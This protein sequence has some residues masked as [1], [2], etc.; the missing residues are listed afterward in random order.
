MTEQNPDDVV[1]NN[2]PDNEVNEQHSETPNEEQ[3]RIKITDIV[4]NLTE[5]NDC[6]KPM[7][8]KTLRYSHPSV[9]E[10]KPSNVID[11]PV[12]KYAPRAKTKINVEPLA[13]KQQEN[14]LV[15]PQQYQEK[16]QPISEAMLPQ[17][18][19][20]PQVP[21]PYDN[22]TQQQL[23]HLQMGSMNTEIMRRKQEKL[24]ICVNQCLNQEVKNL[25]NNIYKWCYIIGLNFK[26]Q[27]TT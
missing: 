23:M 6:K 8:V 17:Q 18:Q 22:L 7:T 14:K 13:P 21:N 3:K 15:A 19:Q 25:N 11:K 4:K 9:C 16:Q 24:I 2:E 27:T 1:I 5:C 20:Q 26:K 12:K 10:K